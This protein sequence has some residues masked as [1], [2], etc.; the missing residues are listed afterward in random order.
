MLSLEAY[1]LQGN[2]QGIPDGTYTR[3]RADLL[4][5]LTS[6]AEDYKKEHP[7]SSREEV[8]SALWKDVEKWCKEKGA[9]E[10]ECSFRI[11]ECMDGRL[12]LYA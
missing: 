3:V 8:V 9:T 7:E 10:V 1:F 12:R 11:S 4:V 5:S 6:Y 2:L